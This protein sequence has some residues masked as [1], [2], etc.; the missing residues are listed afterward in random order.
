M[1]TII[2]LVPS[3]VTPVVAV[4]YLRLSYDTFVSDSLEGQEDDC[5]E[6]ARQ[7]GA[8]TVVIFR[9]VVTASKVKV[10]RKEF[11]AM[12]AYVLDHKPAFLIAWKIDRVTRQGIRQ[13]A[14]IV[15]LVEDTGVRFVSLKDNLDSANP[16]WV[17]LAAFLAEQAKEEAKNIQ[18]RVASR[19]ARDRKKGRWTKE[20]P[21]GFV[22][23]KDRQLKEHPIEGPIVRDM[24]TEYLE[25]NGSLS[26]IAA[27]LTKEGI[28][29]LRYAKRE[30]MLLRLRVE[31]RDEE[32]AQ[33]E[34][35]SPIKSRNSWGLTTVRHILTSPTLIGY[36]PHKGEIA[37][38]DDGEPIRVGKGLISE[39]KRRR[40]LAR[41]EGR[42]SVVRKPGKRTG[43]GGS[44]GRPVT[45]L[46]AGY[47]RCGDCAGAMVG[48]R[49]RPP[50]NSRYYCVAKRHGHPCSGFSLV[51]PVVEQL[52]IDAVL[53]RLAAMEPD[54]P[55]LVAVAQR[56]LATYAPEHGAERAEY[57][58]KAQAL[59][60]RLEALEDAR[61]ER[62][63]FDD[64]EGP[65]RYERRRERIAKQLTAVESALTQLPEPTVDL[66]ML[67]DP[68]EAKKALQ[69]DEP[70]SLQARRDVLGLVLQR[71]YVVDTPELIEPIW[72]GDDDT[73]VP[74]QLR[75]ENTL[76]LAA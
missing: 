18:L 6:R 51:A 10:R 45:F 64:A 61:W 53:G 9:E 11:D 74:V 73:F 5:I 2:Q 20:R 21:F 41:L 13:L 29:T 68:V 19:Q 48:M 76:K 44:P 33:I 36:L 31:G 52:V 50:R 63:E 71:V 47:F 22:V 39:A 23:T 40:V 55:R 58:N 43:K 70:R 38:G 28:P 60:S 72:V 34:R 26:G 42:A 14:D 24:V 37:E 66:S 8:T 32:A 62:G 27:R 49:R 59:R 75:G 16:G 25:K 1:P 15:E 65:A 7:L 17:T 3:C 12:R 56:W 54:D 69:D 35:D 67:L 30:E 46:L 57:E 4:L